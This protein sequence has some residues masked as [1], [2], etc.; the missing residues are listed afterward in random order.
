MAKV[1]VSFDEY[2]IRTHAFQTEPRLRLLLRIILEVG[3]SVCIVLCALKSM[4][5]IHTLLALV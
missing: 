2:A 1:H 4:E 5:F 3:V